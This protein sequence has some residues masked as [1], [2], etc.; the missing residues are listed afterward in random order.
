MAQELFRNYH[1]AHG[2]ARRAMKIDL[3]KAFDSVRWEFLFDVLNHFK[4]P[5][6]FIFWLRACITST[7]FSVKVNGSLCGFFKG[8]KGLRQ[9]DPLSPYVFVI[10]ME[11]LSLSIAKGSSNPNFQYQWRTKHLGIT[12]LCFTDDLILFCHGDKSSVT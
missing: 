8:A 7:K 6:K 2:P 9:G 10:I 1:R 11:A 12:H 4:F 3:K 5:P